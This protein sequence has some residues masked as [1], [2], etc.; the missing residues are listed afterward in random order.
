MLVNSIVVGVF[1]PGSLDYATYT[2]P[3]FNVA[4]GS[5]TIEFLGLDTATGDNTAFVNDIRLA[6]ATLGPGDAGFETPVVGAGL[7]QAAPTGTPW[8]F[9]SD[10]HSGIAGN[11]SGYTF[12][13]PSAPEGAQVAFLQYS[14]YLYQ[15]VAGWAAGSYIISFYAA[16][17]ANSGGTY[18]DQ[19]FE[20]LVDGTVVGTFTPTSG[21]Y[22]VY[23]TPAFTVTA[24]SH[25]IK[26]LGLD[27]ATG[28]NT[29]L[30]NAI[31]VT[32]V[33]AD[34][35]YYS[36]DDQVIEERVGGTAAGNVTYQYVWGAGYVNQMV[37]RDTY[38]GGVEQAS[39]RLY[40]QWNAN[41]DV[42][43]LV[44]TSGA[45]VERYLY[46]PYGSATVTNASW[47][48]LAGNASAYGWLYLHQGGR[49][50]TVT[51]WY[52]FR[53]RDLI[54]SEG[55]WAERDPLGFG[56]SQADLYEFMFG[57][58]VNFTDPSGL[59]LISWVYTGQ[60][61]PPQYVWDAAT[62]SAGDTTLRNAAKI[63]TITQYTG[64]IDPTGTSGAI[65]AG[66]QYIQGRDQEAAHTLI[67]T[68][69][70]QIGTKLAGKALGAFGKR[71]VKVG[72]RSTFDGAGQMARNGVRP[73]QKQ[74]ANNTCAPTSVGMVLD[75][76]NPGRASTAFINR[77]LSSKGMSMS[78][79]AAM[80]RQSGVQAT[81]RTGYNIADI[82]RATARG[83]PLIAAVRVPG[84]GFHAI[85]IDGV[86]TR[87][88]QA[89]VAIRDPGDG[90]QY[91]EL[92]I[93]FAQRFTGQVVTLP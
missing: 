54:P 20:V 9:S 66:T 78:S 44:N 58:P 1:T 61:D 86:T 40:A 14:G 18:Q 41:Y 25:T 24:G 68:G 17:R 60:W 72:N 34:H 30:V 39:Q 23:T 81:H 31:S 87:M 16:Q 83:N 26:F 88:G 79:T 92:V 8:T 57:S 82:A 21:S 15:S 36:A 48:P 49:M 77:A 71:P 10:S 70:E 32:P 13:N 4:A 35:L 80:L 52:A 90:R 74:V 89:V 47:T 28:D 73:V 11:T 51:G 75:T 84:G 85:V 64:K 69:V 19:N 46:D 67:Q 56:G 5:H 76:V 38:S 7:Y 29:A 2:T 91:F 63:E 55:R 42:T 93:T 43:A 22:A 59:G 6:A 3:A 62:G 45:V 53:N 33:T 50:D 65:R 12:Y 37:L 27:T